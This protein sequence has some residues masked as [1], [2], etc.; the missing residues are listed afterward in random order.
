MRLFPSN[1]DPASRLLFVYA[2]FS[3]LSTGALAR[4]QD[5]CKNHCRHED[6]SNNR[7]GKGFMTIPEIASMEAIATS[8]T[9]GPMSHRLGRQELMRPRSRTV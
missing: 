4:F 5:H 9:D 1:R 6:S 3:W 7:Q 2:I 8:P